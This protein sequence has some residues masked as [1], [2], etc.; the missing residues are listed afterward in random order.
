VDEVWTM[1][2]GIASW[3]CQF[4]ASLAA[5]VMS[6]GAMEVFLAKDE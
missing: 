5:M 4:T 3:I 6:T 1:H 2:L